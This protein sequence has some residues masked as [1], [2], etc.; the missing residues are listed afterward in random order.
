MSGRES[1]S[2]IVKFKNLRPKALTVT[3]GPKKSVEHV[4]FMMECVYSVPGNMRV[5]SICVCVGCTGQMKVVVP[6]D[7][8][9][10]EKRE[11]RLADLSQRAFLIGSFLVFFSSP[12][13]DRSAN[14]WWTLYGK[15]YT[16]VHFKTMFMYSGDAFN[17]CRCSS[18]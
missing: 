2:V 4:R 8:R 1:D 10:K 16:F 11:S 14:T 7:H 12:G 18:V 13:A 5:C 3:G 9:Y 6:G 17:I 15:R